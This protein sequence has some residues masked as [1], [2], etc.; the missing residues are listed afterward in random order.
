MHH[1]DS[2]LFEYDQTW[3]AEV[4]EMLDR[5][6]DLHRSL[7]SAVEF[8]ELHNKLL[9]EYRAMI[10]TAEREIAGAELLTLAREFF[11]G[12]TAALLPYEQ[13]ENDRIEREHVLLVEMRAAVSKRDAAIS[14]AVES[15]RKAISA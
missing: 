13:A 7:R 2:A 6:E 1:E 8:V 15:L 11:R 10:E 12:D 9:K 5:T 14:E 3:L 4:D